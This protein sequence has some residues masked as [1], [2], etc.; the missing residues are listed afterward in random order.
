MTT[1]ETTIVILNCDLGPNTT[2]EDYDAWVDYVCVNIDEAC[3]FDVDVDR[4]RFPR[5]TDSQRDEIS[6]PST[7]SMQEDA[8]REETI[9]EALTALW[10]RG[11]AEN[12]GKPRAAQ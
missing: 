4:V 6:H 3:G 7:S 1:N 8:A 10:N 5:Q 9:R 11:C 12:F 2:A